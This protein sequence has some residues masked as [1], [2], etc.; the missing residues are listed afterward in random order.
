VPKV[1]R[2]VK[3]AG[4]RLILCQTFDELWPEE[5]LAERTLGV[6]IN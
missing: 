5:P 2:T 3:R 4:Q 6:G 1:E